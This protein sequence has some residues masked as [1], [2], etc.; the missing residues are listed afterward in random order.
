MPAPE[1]AEAARGEVISAGAKMV[2]AE[3]ACDGPRSRATAPEQ[4]GDGVSGCWGARA[5][6]GVKGAAAAADAGRGD[7]CTHMPSH[8]PRRH[9]HVTAPRNGRR[10]TLAAAPRRRGTRSSSMDAGAGRGT[11]GTVARR[12]GGRR[13]LVPR[14]CPVSFYLCDRAVKP[15]FTPHVFRIYVMI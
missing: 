10:W 14:V 9:S 13:T 1:K 15:L 4:V 3:G 5:G 8:T 12:V 11:V 6:H 2:P 7:A